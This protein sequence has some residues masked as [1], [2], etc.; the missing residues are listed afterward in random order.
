MVAKNSF[1]NLCLQFFSEDSSVFF[2]CNVIAL[3]YI[4]DSNRGCWGTNI[5]RVFDPYKV[6]SSSGVSPY[7]SSSENH[8][9]K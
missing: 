7:I 3:G 2:K 6:R 9:Y 8:I 5:T 4:H 1:A